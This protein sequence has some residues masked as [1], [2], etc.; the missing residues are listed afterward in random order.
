MGEKIAVWLGTKKGAFVA[1]SSLTG[2]DARRS[3]KLEGPFFRG[4][5][6]NH[7]VQDPRDPKRYYAAVNSAWFGPHVHASVD[8]GKTWKLSDQGLTL[9]DLPDQTLKR[10]WHIRPGH[11]DE[12]AVVYAGADPG[13]LFRST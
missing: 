11:A 6:V 3:W 9:R 8:G 12:P 4:N 7:V 1:R 10:I 13:A 2:A 5:E